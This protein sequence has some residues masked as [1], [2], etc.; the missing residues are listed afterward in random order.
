MKTPDK[1]RRMIRAIVAA[2]AVGTV[3]WSI[4]AAW[5]QGGGRG[6]AVS[7][8]GPGKR[9]SP[10]DHYRG[11]SPPPTQLTLTL[12]GGQYLA[13][14]W[15]FYE[16]VFMPLQM[17]IYVY[18]KTMKPQTAED[19]HVT[20]SLQLPDERKTRT[21]PFHHVALPKGSLDQDYVVAV[22]DAKLLKDKETPITFEFSGLPDR[23]RT[24]ASFTP[25]F[26]RATV[27]PY[28]ARVLATKADTDA[29]L[30]QRVCPVCGNLLGVRSPVVK[31]MIGD[32]SAFVCCPKCL[33]DF[34]ES[35]ERR[36]SPARRN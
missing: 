29:V 18:D 36:V 30:H 28:V 13:T 5:G 6:S 4:S 35:P 22:F 32:R 14:E 17:R 7:P 1:H 34:R 33:D 9:S 21:I 19:V 2:I 8:G 3:A 15:N 10:S 20:M 11:D 12:H 23:H 31:L 26:S 16:V 25:L 24:T 27:R